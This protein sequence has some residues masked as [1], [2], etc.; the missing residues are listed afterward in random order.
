MQAQ[1]AGINKVGGAPVLRFDGRRMSRIEAIR[2]I[3]AAT[4]NDPFPRYGL[5]LEF[6]NAG[7]LAEAASAFNELE[8]KFP[9]YVPQYLMHVQVLIAKG[10]KATAREVCE[11]GL[12]AAAK[13]G[14]GHARGELAGVL[15]TLDDE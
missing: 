11:R 9:D 7:Q 14:D 10:D 12:T 13:K 2:K 1:F 8:Q 3:I 5:A 6:K 4:P 15:D